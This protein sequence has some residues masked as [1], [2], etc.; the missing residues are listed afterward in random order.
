[1]KLKNE[2]WMNLTYYFIRSARILV[3][4]LAPV[5][6]SRCASPQENEIDYL[7]QKPPGMEAELFAPGIISTNSMNIVPRLF[8]QMEV[9]F[10][11][12]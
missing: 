3:G 8:H 5:I 2:T 10:S 6:L 12:R 9:L 7:G 1:M 4:L 11:G